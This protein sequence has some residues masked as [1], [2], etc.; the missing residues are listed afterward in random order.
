MSL[1]DA[2]P[3]HWRKKVLMHNLPN[4]VINNNETPHVTLSKNNVKCVTQVSSRELYFVFLKSKE[5]MPS[6][7]KAWGERIHTTLNTD[8]WKKIFLLPKVTV[9]D[10]RI[11]DM[12]FKVVHRCYA[13]NSIISKWDATKSNICDI[14]NQ[15]ANIIHNF[16]SCPPVMDFWI[17]VMIW[18]SHIY[19]ME[20]PNYTIDDIIFGKF[21][22]VKD[23]C[24]NHI[25]LYTKYL[26]HKQ[27]VHGKELFIDCFKL[28]YLKVLETE[29]ERYTLN[30]RRND[31]QKR[32]GN[33]RLVTE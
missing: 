15:K 31:F 2:I 24:L 13:T 19:Y 26:I 16:V 30:N 12:Q 3:P 6:C 9:C 27:F 18:F 32:F 28:F 23:D 5:V 14:C 20:V 21:K 4:N 7:C 17:S 8:E 22:F 10:T 33:C 25:I 29:R 11:L 1:I